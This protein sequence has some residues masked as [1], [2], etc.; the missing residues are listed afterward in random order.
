MRARQPA[1]RL[2]VLRA[3]ACSVGGVACACAAW[4]VR[5]SGPTAV[6]SMTHTKALY[7]S[8]TTHALVVRS[9]AAVSCGRVNSENHRAPQANQKIKNK[10]HMASK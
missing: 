7:E 9:T 4:G 8:S 10:T 1:S 2:P 5:C 3:R 6:A